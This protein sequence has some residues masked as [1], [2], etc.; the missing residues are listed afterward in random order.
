MPKGEWTQGEM[1]E[2]LDR[3][4]PCD[5]IEYQRTVFDFAEMYYGDRSDLSYKNLEQQ[6]RRTANRHKEYNPGDY[7]GRACRSGEEWSYAELRFLDWA[8]DPAD[9]EAKNPTPE[10]LA[11]VLY[12]TVAEV[13]EKWYAK[14]GGLKG[15]FDDMKPDGGAE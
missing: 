2:L 14:P 10:Y 12:R 6:L 8:K 3:V 7:T 13:R 1:D 4:L 9:S 11:G 5:I 15:F